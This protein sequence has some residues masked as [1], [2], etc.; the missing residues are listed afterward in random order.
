MVPFYLFYACCVVFRK[1]IVPI[2]K[3]DNA[4][5]CTVICTC[6]VL[7]QLGLSVLQP[8]GTKQVK[9]EPFAETGIDVSK[10]ALTFTKS[11]EMEPAALVFCAMTITIQSEIL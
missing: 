2:G 11:L 8:L 9:S 1:N 10:L 5:E 7:G 3:M 4:K 6:R